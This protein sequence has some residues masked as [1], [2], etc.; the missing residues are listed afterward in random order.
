[1]RW[2]IALVLFSSPTFA[3]TITACSDRTADYPEDFT[4][5]VERICTKLCD[6]DAMC[7]HPSVIGYEECLAAC[8]IPGGMHDDTVCGEAFRNWFGCAAD[9][10]SCAEYLDTFN[11]H[12]EDY[13][14]KEE[15]LT[16]V[17]LKCGA[18]EGN[19]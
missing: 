12:A 19:D 9:T 1:M 16:V 4:E 10:E 15:T 6:K 8:N 14:C 3:V 13:T 11:V 2:S 18:D 7:V 17:A 5:E